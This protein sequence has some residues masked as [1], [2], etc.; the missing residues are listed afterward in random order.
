MKYLITESKLTSFIKDRFD[1]DLT[2]R[3]ELEP[4]IYG[5]LND[6]DDCVSYEYLSRRKSSVTNYG[7]MYLI[8][9][10]DNFKILY[11]KNLKTDM[12]WIISNRCDTYDEYDFMNLLGISVLGLNMDDFIN[13]YL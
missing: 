10:K 9:L 12:A 2:G 5:I 4:S 3:V 6:F 11:Q 1:I 13:L 7:P 8:K